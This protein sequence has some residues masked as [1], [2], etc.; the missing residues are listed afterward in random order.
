[1]RYRR[2]VIAIAVFIEL[3][4]VG[5]PATA[6]IRDDEGG[7]VIVDGTPTAIVVRGVDR[8]LGFYKSRSGR[9]GPSWTCGYHELGSGTDTNIPTVRPE[10]VNPV[11]GGKYGFLCYDEVGR[12]VHEEYLTYEPGDPLAGLFAAERAAELALAQLE[13]PVPEIHVNPPG[14]QLVG[15]AT[16]LWVAGEWGPLATAASFGPV[17]STVR[18]TPLD[19]TWELGD[20]TTKVCSGPGVA[21]DPARPPADQHSDCRHV[22]IWP[23]YA[24]PGGTYTVTATVR[25]AVEWEATTGAAGDLGVLTRASDL[26]VVVREVQALV[27]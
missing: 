17:T 18:A 22:Y 1:M 27:R 19:V 6:E 13:L 26:P 14:E 2:L 3:G 5:A 25:Y 23:S 10:V 9:S 7:A 16:W 20:G 8:D 15:L 11:V 12:L 21:Y 24:Q 4:A